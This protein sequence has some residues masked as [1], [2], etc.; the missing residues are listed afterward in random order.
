MSRVTYTN[1]QDVPE[2]EGLRAAHQVRLVSA[3]EEGTGVNLLPGGV[4]GYTYSPALDGA[5]LFASRAFRSYEV[6]KLPSGEITLIGFTTSDAA[7][8]L[9]TAPQD[10]TIQVQPHPE[11]DQDTLVEIPYS[12]IRA[13]RQY[14]APNTHGFSATVAPLMTH[15]G[16]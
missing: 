12:R 11:P 13:H 9:T 8:Q 7:R 6:H 5:P 14:A 4:Y 3:E 2:Q 10:V 16:A 1:V 15:A